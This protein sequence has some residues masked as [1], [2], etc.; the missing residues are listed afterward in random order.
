MTNHSVPDE[1]YDAYF[2]GPDEL[3]YFQMTVH[4]TDPFYD[5]AFDIYDADYWEDD[6][7]AAYLDEEKAA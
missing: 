2:D 7:Y 3:D 5:E 4:E 1:F 6:D